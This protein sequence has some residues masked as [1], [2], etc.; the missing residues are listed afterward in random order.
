VYCIL[1]ATMLETGQ[2]C[3]SAPNSPVVGRSQRLLSATG[4]LKFLSRS[5]EDVI[6]RCHSPSPER[7][8]VLSAVPRHLCSTHRSGS[9]YGSWRPSSPVQLYR[10]LRTYSAGSSESRAARGQLRDNVLFLWRRRSCVSTCFAN[11]QLPACIL[12][13]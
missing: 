1:R 12:G 8:E 7:A 4:L 13:V 5:R 11:R 6:S 3:S 2:R 10:R 9:L